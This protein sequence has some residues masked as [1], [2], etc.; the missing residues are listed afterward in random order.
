MSS[1]KEVFED[2]PY[3]RMLDML[4]KGIV[5]LN[6]KSIEQGQIYVFVRKNMYSN[7]A[8]EDLEVVKRILPLQLQTMF[9]P[10]Y[11]L[12]LLKLSGNFPSNYGKTAGGSYISP[13]PTSDLYLMSCYKQV[14]MYENP[15]KEKFYFKYTNVDTILYHLE[16]VGEFY[17]MAEFVKEM[18]N[19]GKYIAEYRDMNWGYYFKI[20]INSFMIE[21]MNWQQNPLL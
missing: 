20:P 10:P 11:D 4:S 6:T 21:F 2:Y 14:L 3:D 15:T 19:S 17:G 5:D 12:N 1:Y 7:D 18:K 13:I 8:K 9:F 16:R